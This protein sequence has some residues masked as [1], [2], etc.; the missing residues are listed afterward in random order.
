MFAVPFVFSQAGFVAGV[1]YLIVFAF[2]FTI[3]HQMYAEIIQG[4]P[5]RHRFVGYAEIYLGRWGVWASMATTALGL[6]L[7]LTVYMALASTFIPLIAPALSGAKAAYL[8]W[9]AGSAAVVASLFRLAKADVLVTGV[10][11]FI[12]LYLFVLGLP[13]SANIEIPIFDRAN[14]FLP[15]GVV[16][17]SLAGRAA[18]SSL[19]AYAKRT[20]TPTAQLFRAISLGTGI[21]AALYLLFAFAVLWLSGGEVTP[22]ALTGL[23]LLPRETLALLGVLGV[24]ALFTSYFFLGLEVRDILRLDFRWREGA[25]LL[26]VLIAPLLFYVMGLRNF[27]ELVGIVGGVF[28]AGESAMVALMHSKMKGGTRYALFFILVFLGGA[29]YELAGIV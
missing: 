11:V 13:A 27:I 19:F 20:R 14:L 15:Y 7:V 2:V 21:P 3:V 24:V 25:A 9:A 6:M 17:F 22:D 29:L 1:F 26:A 10:M 4:T 12:V 23:A 18:I 16:L 28:L 8:F 5:G